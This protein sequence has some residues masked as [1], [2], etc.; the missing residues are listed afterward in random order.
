MI[1][2]PK[3]KIENRKLKIDSLPCPQGPEKRTEAEKSGYSSLALSV[4]SGESGER[5]IPEI[6]E[7][8]RKMEAKDVKGGICIKIEA[9][10]HFFM[11]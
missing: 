6:R 4:K 3:L 1:P 10:E 7:N 11:R 2:T 9:L 5:R 8:G